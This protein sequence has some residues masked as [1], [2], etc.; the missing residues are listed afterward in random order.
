MKDAAM[1]KGQSLF[2]SSYPGIAL[3]PVDH[4]PFQ[5]QVDK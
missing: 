2:S 4:D 1:H 3:N 5:E